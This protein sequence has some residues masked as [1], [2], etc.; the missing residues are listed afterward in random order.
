L[1]ANDLADDVD[2]MLWRF[3]ARSRM[4]QDGADELRANAARMKNREWSHNVI[5]LLLGQRSL[6][7]VRASAGKAEEKCKIEFYTGQ[8]HLLRG[9]RTEAATTLRAAADICPKDFI[10]YEGAMAELKRLNP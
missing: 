2:S 1:R 5:D 3:L 6:Q 8:L 4:G 7:E 10:E 9:T